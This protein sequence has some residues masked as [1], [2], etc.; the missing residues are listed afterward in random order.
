M[1]CFPTAWKYTP[2]LVPKSTAYAPDV[3]RRPHLGS[4]LNVKMVCCT[5]MNTRM[6]PSNKVYT[7]ISHPLPCTVHGSCNEAVAATCPDIAMM[8]GEA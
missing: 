8:Q 4:Q 6:V 5:T 3:D 1:H 7:A 2:A